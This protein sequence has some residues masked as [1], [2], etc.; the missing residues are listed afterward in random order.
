MESPKAPTQ[1]ASVPVA[2][3]AANGRTV[4]SLFPDADRVFLDS[5]LAGDPKA[6]DAFI[7]RYGGLLALVVDRTAAQRRAP[8]TQADRDDLLADV[9]LGLLHHDAAVLRG[10][11]GRSSL[12]SYLTVVA[13]R[14]VLPGLRRVA[15]RAGNGSR[16]H[17]SRDGVAGRVVR[18]SGGP[19]VRA[20]G[21]SESSPTLE[22]PGDADPWA[23]LVRLH[24]VEGRSF[25]EISR[26]TGLPL[27]AIGPSL[28][29]ARR[30]LGSDAG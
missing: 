2:S 25:G 8:L 24:D 21:P 12:A 4:A 10:F 30:K 23:R 14:I 5:C 16:G 7:E 27:A 29:L 18:E 6:W 20:E 28:K 15:A 17:Q 3:T 22:G 13:R 19:S 26:I 1:E 11:S 9:L